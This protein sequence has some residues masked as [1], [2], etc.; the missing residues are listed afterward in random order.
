MLI[1]YLTVQKFVW[2]LEDKGIF[3]G[4]AAKQSDINEGIYDHTSI[5]RKISKDIEQL[6]NIQATELT[7]LQFDLMHINRANNCISS[8]Y[9]GCTESEKMWEE[10]GQDGIAIVSSEALLIHGT[11]EPVTQ[12]I[13]YYAVDY[14]NKKKPE[15]QIEPLRIK[16]EK[17]SHENEFRMVVDMQNY[18]MLTGF[19]K[20]KYGETFIGETPSYESKEITA[21]MSEMGGR[22]SHEIIREKGVGYIV[23]FDMQKIIKEIILSPEC[24]IEGEAHIMKCLENAGIQI[25]VRHSALRAPC[26]HGLS[27]EK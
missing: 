7:S 4:P 18:S 19:E 13:R 26:E 9:R 14:D 21:C 15:T 16:E 17:F 24:T 6:G 22:Q 2:L 23:S 1:R 11:P 20:E 8:W 3:F 12:S 10:Y 25:H 5:V 27:Q